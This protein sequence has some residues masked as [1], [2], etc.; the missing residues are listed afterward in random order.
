MPKQP[1]RVQPACNVLRGH[2]AA[3]PYTAAALTSADGPGLSVCGT[4][5]TPCARSESQSAGDASKLSSIPP[6][7]EGN[8]PLSASIESSSANCQAR[9]AKRA[10]SSGGSLDSDPA[11]L[12]GGGA[13][14]MGGFFVAAGAV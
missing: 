3:P 11:S 8:T 13:G 10:G 6:A 14:A 1:M 2:S 5:A 4:K 12:S 9:F 7:T